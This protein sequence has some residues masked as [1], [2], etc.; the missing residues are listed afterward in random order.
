M[1]D[2]ESATATRHSSARREGMRKFYRSPSN[3]ESFRGNGS[4]LETAPPRES[5]SPEA[6]E[7]AG[8]DGGEFHGTSIRHGRLGVHRQGT[9]TQAPAGGAL[10]GCSGPQ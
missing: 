9:G 2:P 7:E 3:Y 4:W 5:F 1:T 6:G 10:G 8:L